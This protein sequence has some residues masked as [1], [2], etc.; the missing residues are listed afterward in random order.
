MNAQLKMPGPATVSLQTLQ[1]DQAVIAGK[2]QG[3]PVVVIYC[4]FN[5]AGALWLPIRDK[6]G[7]GVWSSTS[8]V[9]IQE[10]LGGL[11]AQGIKIERGQAFNNWFSHV[12]GSPN[13]TYQ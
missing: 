13:R 7:L 6:P 3:C 5:Q 4:R 11:E 12:A 1:D 8:P 2:L 10:F 9:S